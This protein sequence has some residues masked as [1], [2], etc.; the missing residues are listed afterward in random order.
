M[1]LYNK[2]VRDR[3]PELIQS[4]GEKATVRTLEPEAFLRC[5]EEKLEEELAEYRREGESGNRM[6]ELAD[7]LEVV[8]ALA[9]TQGCTEEALDRIRLAKRENRGGFAKRLFLVSKE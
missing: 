5:L 9:A 4:H 6:E 3:I 7:I 1:A 2:L 8:Y